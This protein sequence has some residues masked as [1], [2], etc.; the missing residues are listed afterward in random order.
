MLNSCSKI[1]QV[2]TLPLSPL[3]LKVELDSLSHVRLSWKDNSDNELGFKIERKSDNQVFTNLSILKAN[4]TYF[5]DSIVELS[6]TYT[7][8]VFSYNSLGSS[9][10]YSNE[11]TISVKGLAKINTKP[12]FDTGYTSAKSGGIIINDG[13]LGIVEKGIVWST[14]PSPTILLTS[15]T[16][17][18]SAS[19]DFESVIN[20]LKDNTTYYVR[21]FVQNSFGI[22]YGNELT[23]KT[24]AYALPIV[25]SI[26]SINYLTSSSA[27]SGGSISSDG[28]SVVSSRGVCWSET[29]NPSINNNKTIDGN[30]KGS[31][32]SSISGL[33]ENT[34]Y[35]LRA[36]ATNSVGTAYSNQISFKTTSYIPTSVLIGTQTWMDKNLDVSTYRN[37]DPIPE[38]KD[39]NEWINLKTGAWCYYNN[40]PKN[41]EIYGKLYNWYAVNDPRGLAPAGWHI[42]SLQEFSNLVTFLGGSSVAGGKLKS[43]ILWDPPNVAAS[44]SS[45][46]NALPGGKGQANVAGY[47]EQL[48]ANAWFWS[49]TLDAT[50]DQP[51]KLV[52]YS[53]FSNAEVYSNGPTKSVGHSIRCIKD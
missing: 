5:K 38:V 42:P 17:N 9:L 4:S 21:S 2:E 29:Q 11:V 32:V 26:F 18:G 33:R 22:S 46:F 40:D 45:K 1:K 6:K 7:Y 51:Y 10:T 36:Y 47:F 50:N 44:N 30:G 3:D 34:T 14:N 27:T 8:R 35:Y 16:T 43:T 15:K 20:N 48:G 49:K 31:F 19:S 37:G 12:I 39:Y 52:L 41:G 23:F 13:G 25:D 28:G 24:K 53:K